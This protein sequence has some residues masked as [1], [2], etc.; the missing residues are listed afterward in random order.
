[1]NASNYTNEDGVI[2]LKKAYLAT[3]T[4]G[5]KVFT[6]VTEDGA[7]PTCTITITQ[8]ASATATPSTASFDKKTELQADIA[9]VIANSG[10]EAV[11]NGAT[12][13]TEDTDY[14]V[15]SGTVTLKKEYLATLSVGTETI[16]FETVDEV[17]PTCTIT[18]TQTE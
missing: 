2:T 4:T 12:A 7:N 5:E 1:M 11:K 8:T 17:N 6:F 3:Q 15:S 13:L 14:T 9:V 16:T 18:V 10:L